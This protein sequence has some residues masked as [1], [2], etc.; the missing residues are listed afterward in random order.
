[1]SGTTFLKRTTPVFLFADWLFAGWLLAGWFVLAVGCVQAAGRPQATYASADEAVSAL[2]AA[3]RSEGS[4]ALVTVLGPEGAAIADSGDTIADAAR[5]TKFTAAFDDAHVVKQE[6]ASKAVLV[7]GRES[8]PFPI[9]LVAKDGK[10][11][12]DSA[13]GLEE[14]LTRRIGENELAAIEVMR[15]Y[16]DAQREYAETDYDGA[17][18][19]YARRLLS[20]EGRK[21]GLYWPAAGEGE[22]SPFGPL[23]AKAQGEGYRRSNGAE[24]P[25]AYHGY[26]YRVL[27]AQGPNAA[28]GA[29][30]YIV[31]N[32]MIGGF[33]L[34]ATP[35]N[36]GNSGV[37]TLI[38]NQ[39][40]DVFEKDLGPLSKQTAARIKTFDP[41]PDWR[42]I[43][44][45]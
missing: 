24:E 45:Q 5:R 11:Q 28:G 30:D 19:Q 10:W 41:G 26:H 18:I 20:R 3:V 34:I 1:M 44:T 9:P 22:T 31:N 6:N 13:A 40:G 12:W 39:D 33:A 7:I 37:M 29:R 8:F 32:L 43:E 17:G 25:P 38:V 23:V 35:A 21:D 27:Y 42:K 4:D 2:V 14:I 15:A 36:Y 16:V